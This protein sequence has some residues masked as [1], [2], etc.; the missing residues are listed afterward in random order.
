MTSVFFGRDFVSVSAAPGVDWGALRPQVIPVMLDHF[1][2]GAPLF[3]P[4]DASGIAV[5]PPGEEMGDDPADAE[6]VALIKDFDRN[7]R[8]PDRC[9]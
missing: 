2:S 1:L 6:V 5:P 3:K 9:Q 4:A 8:A 7:A